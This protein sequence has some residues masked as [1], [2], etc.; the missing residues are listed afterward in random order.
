MNDQR[1]QGI[2]TNKLNDREFHVRVVDMKFQ[3]VLAKQYLSFRQKK[4]L[5]TLPC[6]SI[7]LARKAKQYRSQGVYIYALRGY[8]LR[9]RGEY[10]KDRGGLVIYTNK[11]SDKGFHIYDLKLERVLIEKIQPRKSNSGKIQTKRPED[12]PV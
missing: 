7:I 6:P 3:G 5:T 8:E 12:Q 9:T 2:N 11:S 4:N 1:G 10:M